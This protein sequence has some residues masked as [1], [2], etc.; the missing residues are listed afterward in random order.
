M[1]LLNSW[2]RRGDTSDYVL[3]FLF[4]SNGE[5]QWGLYSKDMGL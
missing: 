3:P 2:P 5:R 4:L 1:F